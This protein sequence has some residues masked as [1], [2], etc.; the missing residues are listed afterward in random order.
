[1]LFDALKPG[2]YQATFTATDA[3][4]ASKPQSI[5]FTVIRP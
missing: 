2:G 4:G 1:M 5:G 3:T